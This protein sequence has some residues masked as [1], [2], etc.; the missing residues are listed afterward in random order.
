MS[1]NNKSCCL[2]GIFDTL[3]KLIIF[4]V[5]AIMSLTIFPLNLI[6]KLIKNIIENVT[7]ERS[8]LPLSMNSSR[9]SRTIIVLVGGIVIFSMILSVISI[10]AQPTNKSVDSNPRKSPTSAQTLTTTP[11]LYSNILKS[12]TN[13]PDLQPTQVLIPTTPSDLPIYAVIN[14]NANL[15]AGPGIDHAIIDYAYKGDIVSILAKSDDGSWVQID[16]KGKPWINA[17]LVDFSSE[18]IPP[19]VMQTNSSNTISDV[20]LIIDVKNLIGKDIS[21][22]ENILGNTIEINPITDSNDILAGGE[23]RDYFIGKY[24]VFL[25]FD[26]NG[27]ARGFQVLEGLSDENYSI[28]DWEELLSRFG[29]DIEVIAD[30][31]APAAKYWYDYDGYGIAIIATNTSGAPVWTVQIM[32]SSETVSNVDLIKDVN[33]I[34][35]VKN[36]LGKNIPEVENILGGTIEINPITDSNDILAG[37]EYRDYYIGKYLVFLTFD[38]DGIARGFQVLEG[39]RDEN[40]SINDW[41]ELLLRFGL[42]VTSVADKTAPAAK[43]WYDYDG[44]GIAIVASSSSGAPVWTVQVMEAE[45]FLP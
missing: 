13:T 45:Y 7:T 15:R 12:P 29:L 17:S 31:T 11:E 18:N 36:L 34:I 42:D 10:I 27:I 14:G 43:Y 2:I 22:V 33:L 32:E 44:F 26:K 41:E 37:G 39:L 30:E 24:L 23:Y 5:R 8:K 38:K 4:P 6:Y 25:M 28:G 21:D 9:L 16:H 40:Y 35:D 1:G 20:N 3:L 19:V